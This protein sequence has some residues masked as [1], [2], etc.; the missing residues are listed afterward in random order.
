MAEEKTMQQEMNDEFTKLAFNN[1]QKL[2]P[3][4]ILDH[5]NA[6]LPQI[7]S[8]V[9]T[10]IKKNIKPTAESLG[11]DKIFMEMNIPYILPDKSTIM[12][13]ALFKIDKRQLGPSTYSIK[14]NNQK[15]AKVYVPHNNN[16]ATFDKAVS[17]QTVLDVIGSAYY[18]GHT[19]HQTSEGWILNSDVEISNYQLNLKDGEVPE[20][21]FSLMTLI[22]KIDKYD[23]MEDLIKDVREGKFIS[24]NDM[25]YNDYKPKVESPEQKQIEPPQS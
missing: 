1:I 19:L 14:I 15:G 23:K 22:E 21:T 7:L 2:L 9:K 25:H 5:I 10:L 20:I 12:V 24:L 4:H 16:F 11:N 18:N 6:V 17:F 3:Q 8:I 13:P